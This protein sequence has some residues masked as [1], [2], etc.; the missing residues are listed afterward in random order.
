MQSIPTPHDASP[1]RGDDVECPVVRENF[2]RFVSSRTFFP[3]DSDSDGELTGRIG[4]SPSLK[5]F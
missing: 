5:R 4:E 3:V 1:K 2:R